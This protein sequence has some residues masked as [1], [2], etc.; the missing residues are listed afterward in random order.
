MMC[1]L[2]E[3]KGISVYLEKP[4]IEQ[5]KD[6]KCFN[7]QTYLDFNKESNL[8]FGVEEKLYTILRYANDFTEMAKR[9]VEGL[10]TAEEALLLFVCLVNE[11][12]AWIGES[13]GGNSCF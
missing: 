5:I 12:Y 2:D 8:K 4:L 7:Q 1:N 3:G 9:E 6:L 10:F 11:E 13:Q